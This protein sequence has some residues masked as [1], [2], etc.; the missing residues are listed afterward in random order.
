MRLTIALP[1]YVSVPVGGI[2]VQMEYANRLVARGHQVT[3]VAPRQAE[4][5]VGPGLGT[6]KTLAWPAKTALWNRP[7]IP[8][9][10]LD[11]RVR[12]RLVPSLSGVFLPHADVLLGTGWQVLAALRRAPRRAGVPLFIAY[13]YEF[14]RTAPPQKTAAMEAAFRL[15]IPIISTSPSVELMLTSLGIEPI[16]HVTCAIDHDKYF[17]DPSSPPRHDLS[18]GLPLR[19]DPLKGTRD[20]LAAAQLAREKVPGLR[21]EG[22]GRDHISGLPPWLNQRTLDD[23]NAVRRFLSDL[24][25]F[26]FPSHHEGWG[27]PA[28]EAMACGTAVVA[29][30]SVGLRDFTI[31]DETALVVPPGRPTDLAES[32]IRLLRD[33][34]LRQRLVQAARSRI[35]GYSWEQQTDR[36]LEAIHAVGA[37]RER[38]S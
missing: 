9:F 22:M 35:L 26:V 21:V 15:G 32:I 4:F 34:Q 6:L 14:W 23:D 13:D 16:A 33:H 12:F 18:L 17:P 5:T 27:L 29:A 30:D 1:G 8:W 7:L 20:A 19:D 38:S 37:P 11:P 28:M 25:V 36:L 3:L 24:T 31:A 2:R 10:Q